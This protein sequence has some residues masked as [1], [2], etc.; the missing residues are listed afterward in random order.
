ME[1]QQM[2]ADSHGLVS[3]EQNPIV[4]TWVTI[5]RASTARAEFR[6]YATLYSV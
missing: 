4:T 2:T 3:Y 6:S 5:V 1:P